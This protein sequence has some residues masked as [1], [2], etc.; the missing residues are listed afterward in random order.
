L[1]LR[2]GAGLLL[3]SFAPGISG[4]GA[5][6]DTVVLSTT[7]HATQ[8]LRFARGLKGGSFIYLL[9]GRQAAAGDLTGAKLDEVSFR[10]RNFLAV[11][12]SPSERAKACPQR[13]EI[14][15]GGKAPPVSG[16]TGKGEASLGTLLFRLLEI[17]SR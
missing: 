17:A 16:C 7:H 11:S 10:I 9:D 15:V 5:P 14:T 4:A 6:W 1:N 8:E 2:V 3:L 13:Y 12:R